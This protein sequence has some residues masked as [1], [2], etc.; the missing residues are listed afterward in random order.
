MRMAFLVHDAVDAVGQGRYT[1]SLANAFG[2]RHAV[3]VF[4]NRCFKPSGA[5]WSYQHVL[6]SR[7]N[8]LATVLTFPLG[9]RIMRR[10]LASYDLV[11]AQ[12]YC[13]GAPNVITAHICVKAYLRS[14][15]NISATTW[16]SLATM[17]LF[18]EQ[19][20]RR[21]DGPVIA[22]SKKLAGELQQHY[23]FSGRIDV[24]PHGVD[25]GQFN[26]DARSNQ[27]DQ[28][29][30][31]L[32]I[33][34]DRVLALYVGDLLKAHQKLAELVRATPHVSLAL[35]TRS[36]T[37][38]IEAPNVIYIAPTSRIERYYSAADAF[39]FPTLY[40]SFGMVVLEAMACGLPV[41]CSDQAGVAELLEHGRNGFCFSLADWVEGV[42]LGLADRDRLEAVGQ[43]AVR[44]AR[45]HAWPE[46]ARRTEEV[47]R[48]VLE[49]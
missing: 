49:G 13:G 20:Y 42:R 5:V 37:P 30:R 8:A 38:R 34:E 2:E 33:P 39:V 43:E 24:V 27:R 44:T 10:E 9:I 6:A 19:F 36:R 23:R 46:V 40:D 28:V 15:S 48:K 31:E 7:R 22:V 45:R 47:Y 4:A 25:L 1:L 41:F 16:T 26:P 17:A 3:T 18:E 21:F 29:R 35:L 12:G 32:N 14:L 11:H